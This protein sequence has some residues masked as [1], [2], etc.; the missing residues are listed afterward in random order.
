MPVDL[1]YSIWKVLAYFDLFHYPVSRQEIFSFLDQPVTP[2]A[3]VEA[4]REMLEEKSVFMFGEYYSIHNDDGRVLRR[5]EGNCRAQPLLRTGSRI[6]RFLYQVP[7]V[8]AIGI[9]G[10]LSK[11][12][13]AEDAD[14]DYFIITGANR[15][16]VARSMMHV[17]KKFSFLFGRQH[18]YCMN[19][20]I[21]EEALEIEEKNLYTAIE[22]ITLLPVCGNG[23]LHEFFRKNS[24]TGAF[25]PNYRLKTADMDFRRRDSGLKRMLESVFSGRLGDWL[26]NYLM[27]ITSSRWEKKE[28]FER[29]SVKGNRMGLKTGKHFSKPN[30]GFFQKDILNL[31][32]DNL[33]RLYRNT[34]HPASRVRFF[35]SD[36]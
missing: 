27:R 3:L 16:W 2:E 19:Y 4:L 13:A 7:Y 25:Y 20:Y 9:S 18:W 22:L 34:R 30:P 23:I 11:N 28:A 36:K 29:R 12:F 32:G 33:S 26:D 15:L 5:I 6:S 24:W 21:D 10:S 17:F 1:R 35:S 8:R 14:I 31:Y